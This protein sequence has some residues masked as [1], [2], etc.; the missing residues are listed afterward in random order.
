MLRSDRNLNCSADE[1]EVRARR[2]VDTTGV[3]NVEVCFDIAESGADANEGIFLLA[4]DGSHDEQ[5]WCLN[6]P[7]TPGDRDV[8]DFEWPVCVDLPGWAADNPDLELTFVMHS[9]DN[10]DAVYLDDILVRGWPLSCTPSRI[11]AFEEDFEPCAPSDPIADGWNG[12]AVTGTGGPACEDRCTGGSAGG[13]SVL[14]GQW[15]MTHAVDASALQT[16]VRLCFDV[17]GDRCNAG[18]MILVSFD[19]GDGTGLQ[20][21]WYWEQEWGPDGTCQRV[22][23]LLSEIDPD[24]LGEPSLLISFQLTSDDGDRWV[25]IDDVVVDGAGRCDGAGVVDVGAISDGGS[26]DYSFDLTDIAGGPAPVWVTC[27]WDSPTPPV[28]DTEYTIFE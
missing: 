26:G 4:S 8:N 28:E 19:A 22:C 27:S 1:R 17:G 2:G 10:N 16:D 21:A 20:E 5:V 3:G 14:D 15:T 24:V 13:A 25:F 23:V 9:H 18:E 6:G 12:W 7:P 11:V